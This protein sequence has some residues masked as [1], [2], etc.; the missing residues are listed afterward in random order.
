MSKNVCFSYIDK[1]NP[2]N[3]KTGISYN[4]DAEPEPYNVLAP[5][6]LHIQ[7]KTYKFFSSD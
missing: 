2:V 5:T 7:D 1:H 6:V 3:F 4:S